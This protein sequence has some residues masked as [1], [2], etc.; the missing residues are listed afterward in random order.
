MTD[1]QMKAKQM[2]IEAMKETGL[3][4]KVAVLLRR[5]EGRASTSSTFSIVNDF[6]AF[7]L[8]DALSGIVIPC[9][10]NESLQRIDGPYG[11]EPPKLTAP[12]LAA[13]L[14]NRKYK[15]TDLDQIAERVKTAYP[16]VRKRFSGDC[17]YLEGSIGVAPGCVIR[18]GI[19]AAAWV[20]RDGIR[21][22]ECVGCARTAD[23]SHG[24]WHCLLRS[25]RA[26]QALSVLH[27]IDA[28]RGLHMSKSKRGRPRVEFR[29]DRDRYLL[30]SCGGISQTWRVA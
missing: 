23:Q 15:E 26:I 5:I 29:Q 28:S 1:Y 3:V 19:T 21:E 17:K 2:L 9:S 13:Y 6:Y 20:E 4:E 27:W 18:D 11:Y 7:V 24:H 22:L 16:E 14:I 25:P 30:G 10:A 12:E 8:L